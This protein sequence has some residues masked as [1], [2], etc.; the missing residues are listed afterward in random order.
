MGPRGRFYNAC[1]SCQPS[2][3]EWQQ[4]LSLP[5]AQGGSSSSSVWKVSLRRLDA[6]VD[7]HSV[8]M[9]TPAEYEWDPSEEDYAMI[10]DKA[11]AD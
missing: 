8:L 7:A 1:Y 6:L 9:R 5:G 10:A 11:D 3:Q 4:H 2:L